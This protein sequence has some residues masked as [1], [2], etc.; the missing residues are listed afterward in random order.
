MIGIDSNVLIDVLRNKSSISK[1][2]DLPPEE[3]CT[4]EIV[5]YEIFYGIFASREFGEQQAKQFEAIL[6]VFT[7]IFPIERKAS[8]KAAM[9]AGKLSKSGNTIQHTDALIAGSMLA[10]GCSRFLTRNVKDFERIKELDV[11]AY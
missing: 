8:V 7:H 3:M 2:K 5:V 9:I 10:N 11:V 1:L 4:S 6:D